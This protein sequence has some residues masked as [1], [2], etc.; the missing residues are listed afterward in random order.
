MPLQMRLLEEQQLQDKLTIANTWRDWAAA[1]LGHLHPPKPRIPASCRGSCRCRAFGLGWLVRTTASNTNLRLLFDACC[2]RLLKKQRLQ[3]TP[4]IANTWR[5]WAAAPLRRLPLRRLPPL[6]PLHDSK[7]RPQLQAAAVCVY[8]VFRQSWL[9][10]TAASTTDLRLLFDACSLANEASQ[11][12]R[13]V[14]CLCK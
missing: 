11:P 1:P 2:M 10:G 4:T 13:S 9:V 7:P 5:D 6:R 14:R 12:A 8:Q 3:A